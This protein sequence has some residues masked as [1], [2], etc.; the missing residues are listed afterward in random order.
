MGKAGC[1]TATLD[2]R[3]ARPGHDHRHTQA[4][5]ARA[6]LVSPQRRDRRAG[7]ASALCGQ[8]A[9]ATLPGDALIIEMIGVPAR[10]CP[11]RHRVGGFGAIVRQKNEYAVLIFADGLQMRDQPADFAVHGRRHAGIGRHRTGALLPF[12]WRQLR[13]VT[14][15]IHGYH[16]NACGHHALGNHCGPA[17]VA[18]RGPARGVTPGIGRNIGIGRLQWRVVGDEVHR[19]QKRL[20]A[21]V[22]AVNIAD[23]P[24]DN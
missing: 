24:V 18:Q 17:L 11:H 6:E 21:G 20:S 12:L 4:P 16:G 22:A 1:N 19:S 13:P 8:R 2:R 9:R 14:T 5:F 7:K 15:G 23:H 10:K 3:I